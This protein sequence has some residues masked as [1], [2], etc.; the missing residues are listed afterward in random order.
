VPILEGVSKYATRHTENKTKQEKT[1]K[2]RFSLVFFGFQQDRKAV[3][4][5]A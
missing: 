1:R 2:N 5:S 3:K 4:D